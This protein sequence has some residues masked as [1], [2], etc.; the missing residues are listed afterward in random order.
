[1]ETL[2]AETMIIEE[3]IQYER[4]LPAGDYV[5]RLDTMNRLTDDEINA[6]YEAFQGVELLGP[7]EESTTAPAYFISYR[8]SA[9]PGIGFVQLL[10]PLIPTF[11][12]SALIG[13]GIF[14]I[15]ALARNIIPL[16]VIVGAI[17]ISLAALLR[18]QASEYLTRGR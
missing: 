2:V 1:M 18:K 7:I 3:A 13:I 5:L 4:S 10:I 9:H 17:A 8:I 15:E 16:V 6:L 14:R 12:V 11:I